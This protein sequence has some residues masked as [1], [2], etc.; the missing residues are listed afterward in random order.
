MN[1]RFL[2]ADVNTLN[3][4]RFVGA[5]T[6]AALL[7]AMEEYDGEN[8][9][10]GEVFSALFLDA[11][12]EL[13]D[14]IEFEKGKPENEQ[15]KNLVNIRLLTDESE[16]IP[17]SGVKE[18]VANIVGRVK[19]K[20]AVT[21]NDMKERVSDPVAKLKERSSDP[22]ARIKGKTAKEAGRLKEKIAPQ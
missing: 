10:K 22:E 7:K 11:K 16:E 4:S 13:H 14:A 18:K 2:W 1:L 3:A 21:A 5:Q 19:E 15:D 12:K 6:K 20:N 9:E 17:T 8:E